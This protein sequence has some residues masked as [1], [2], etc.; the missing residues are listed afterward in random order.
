MS[1][2]RVFFAMT[3]RAEHDA[4]CY[5]FFY[6]CLAPTPAINECKGKLLLFGVLVVELQTGGLALSTIHADKAGPIL[7]EPCSYLVFPIADPAAFFFL[8]IGIIAL[9]PI[10][11]IGELPF[12]IGIWHGAIA[13]RIVASLKKE[14]T[15][16]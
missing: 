12:P 11:L 8:I 1:H 14:S 16:V 13:I 6:F 9:I 2:T 3:I 4:L 7:F 10:P 15:L 5:L